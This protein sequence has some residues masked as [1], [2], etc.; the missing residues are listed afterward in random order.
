MSLTYRQLSLV[1][2]LV[3]AGSVTITYLS[4]SLNVSRKAIYDDMDSIRVW[5]RSAG[6][7]ELKKDSLGRYEIELKVHDIDSI[8]FS[9][10]QRFRNYEINERHAFLLYF[11]AKSPELTQDELTSK[12]QVSRNT[13]QNDLQMIRKLTI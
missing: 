5:L 2:M 8:L 10:S 3:Y 11:I 6:I 13:L 1:E 4:Q 7:G 9:E 12:L